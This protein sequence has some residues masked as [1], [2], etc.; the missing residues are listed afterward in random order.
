[1]EQWFLEK[2]SIKRYQLTIR[3]Y[4]SQQEELK[5]MFYQSDLVSLPSRTEGFGL[6][7]LE[8]ISA[9]VP[10]LM[11]GESGIAEALHKVEDGQ[12]VVIESDDD[13]AQWVQRI[14]ELSNQSP[15]ERLTNAMKLRENYSKVYSWSGECERFKE[16]IKNIVKTSNGIVYCLVLL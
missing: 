9:G 1:M 16:M 12:S 13:A 6:V 10:V 14:Q 7:A 15:E 4:C 3:S 11:S 8:A 2:T 5:M